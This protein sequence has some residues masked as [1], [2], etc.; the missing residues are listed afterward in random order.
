MSSED[1][2]E[3]KNALRQEMLTKRIKLSVNAKEMADVKICS[4][5]LEIITGRAATV[6]HSYIPM[7]NEVNITPVINKLLQ[8]GV[9]VISPKTLSNRKLENRVLHSL[10]KVEKG[11]FGTVHPIGEASYTG[12]IDLVI[13]P[14]LAFDADNYRLGYG[15]GYYDNFLIKYPKAYKVG[16]FYPFQKVNEVPRESH[17]LRLDSI[18]CPII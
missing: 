1:I 11:V 18:I 6:V 17:D 9:K 2:I 12:D 8:K 4:E 5:L 16:V 10:E 13:V 14:G 3:L 7:S 15:G